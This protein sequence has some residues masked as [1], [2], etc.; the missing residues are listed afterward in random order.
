M[1]ICDSICTS[2]IFRFKHHL[3]RTRNNV[4]ACEKVLEHVRVQFDRL[5]EDSDMATKKKR[6]VFPV[7]EDDEAYERNVRGN[8]LKNFVSK[9][10]KVQRTLNT[11]YKKDEWERVCQQIARFFY[12][13]AIP[14]NCVKNPEFHKMIEIVGEFG[15]GLNPPLL[16]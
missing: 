4:S 8:N 7:D 3:A 10:G 9:K 5:L 13:S 16:P 12:T 14:F 2:G 11:I 1:Y 6:G 15:R